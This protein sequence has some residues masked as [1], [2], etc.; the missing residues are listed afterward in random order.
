M[1]YKEIIKDGYITETFNGLD[2]CIHQ[3]EIDHLNGIDIHHKAKKGVT[4]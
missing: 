4:K 2:A 3:H 1:K